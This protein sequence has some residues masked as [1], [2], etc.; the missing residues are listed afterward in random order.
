[1]TALVIF[2]VLMAALAARA[3]LLRSMGIA[4]VSMRDVSFM[5]FLVMLIVWLRVLG[6]GVCGRDQSS[7][8]NDEPWIYIAVLASV[9]TTWLLYGLVREIRRNIRNDTAP[10]NS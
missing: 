10:R 6:I 5:I 3:P 8:C 7:T 9:A 4:Y 1:M 2:T